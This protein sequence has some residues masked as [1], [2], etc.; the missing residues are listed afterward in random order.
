MNVTQDMV[1]KHDVP[2]FLFRKTGFVK[3]TRR[4]LRTCCKSNNSL[5]RQGFAIRV[6]F[7]GSKKQSAGEWPEVHESSGLT[8]HTAPQFAKSHFTG[9][10]RMM[11]TKQP[12]QYTHHFCTCFFQGLNLQVR[13]SPT[14]RFLYAS[15]PRCLSLSDDDRSLQTFRLCTISAMQLCHQNTHTH[16]HPFSPFYPIVHVFVGR[17]PKAHSRIPPPTNASTCTKHTSRPTSPINPSY[18]WVWSSPWP[19]LHCRTSSCRC[20]SQ[21]A[22]SL[23]IWAMAWRARTSPEAEGE[24]TD[25]PTFYDDDDDYD[26]EAQK[27]SI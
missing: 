25:F 24:Q 8:V 2:L 26:E 13:L 9:C 20:G 5:S 19:S 17:A 11:T 18:L 7:E 23:Q 12:L 6:A 10:I 21:V 15:P 16:K 27:T 22:R 1:S 4:N 14:C 3:K